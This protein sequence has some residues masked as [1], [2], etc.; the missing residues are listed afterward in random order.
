VGSSTTYSLG[1]LNSLSFIEYRFYKLYAAAPEIELFGRDL[2]DSFLQTFKKF[3]QRDYLASNL[4]RFV[5]DAY[6]SLAS[7]NP[8]VPMNPFDHV[9]LL[10]Y[11]L[12]HRSLGCNEIAENPKLLIHTMEIVRAIDW[13]SGFQIMFTGLPTYPRIKKH[14]AGLRLYW[15]L[16]HAINNRRKTGQR[17]TDTMQVLMDQGYSNTLIS[18]VSTQPNSVLYQSKHNFIIFF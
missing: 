8:N 15:I 14:I 10:I 16:N 4:D 7:L 9:F 3:V 13:T 2:A 1:L 11:Q 5:S 18:C 17:Q 12:S 6:T